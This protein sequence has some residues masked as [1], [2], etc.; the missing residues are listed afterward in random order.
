MKQFELHGVVF[1]ST[2]EAARR[3][4]V[5]TK[6]IQRWCSNKCDRPQRAP[7]LKPYR[8]PNG[9]LRVLLRISTRAQLHPEQISATRYLTSLTDQLGTRH[10]QAV[11]Q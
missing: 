10:T 8:G 5:H 11:A 3:L 6:T 1:L 2:G 7:D 9:R 4:R